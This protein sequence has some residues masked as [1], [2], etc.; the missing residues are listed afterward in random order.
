[1]ERKLFCFG[2]FTIGEIDF[3]GVVNT[4]VCHSKSIQFA[5][6]F[7]FSPVF[8]AAI[9]LMLRSTLQADVFRFTPSLHVD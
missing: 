2:C 4:P 3:A 5:I 8:L 6:F 9:S 7:N 1:M